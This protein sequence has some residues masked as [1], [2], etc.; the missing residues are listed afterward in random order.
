MRLLNGS[1]SSK[2]TVHNPEFSDY[3]SEKNGVTLKMSEIF[4]LEVQQKAVLKIIKY[5]VPGWK[6]H[7]DF[8]GTSPCGLLT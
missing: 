5:S 8:S 1:L 4:H 6:A 2:I 3:F 7:D